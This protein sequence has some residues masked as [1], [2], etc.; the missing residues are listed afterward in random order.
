LGEDN[1]YRLEGRG[2]VAVIAPWTFPLAIICGMA[3]GALAAGNCAILKPAAQSPIIA[4]KLAEA[5]HDAGVPGAVLQYLPGPGSVVGQALVEHRDVDNIAFTGSREVGLSIVRAAAQVSKGQR[6]VKR[7]IAEM[8][9]KN[10]IIIDDD[11]DLDQAVAGAVISAFGYAGQKC[12]ACSRLIIAGSA[13]DEALARLGPAVESLIV[14]PAHD[15]ATFVPPVIS[16]QA[17]DKINGYI[18]TGGA[19]AKVLASGRTPAGPGYYVAP[20]VFCDVDETSPL[21]QDEIFGP[22]LSVFQA[23]S[24]EDALRIAMNSAFALT[25]GVYSRNPRH[26]EDARRAFRVGNLYINRKITGAIVGRQPFGGLAMSGIG[27]KAGGPD[28]LLQFME[29]RVISENT[30]RRGF[31]P[32]GHPFHTAS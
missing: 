26:I 30:M 6:N 29:P 14:G 7:V 13:Y 20:T 19:T 18:E 2:V 11:A 15:P 5:L 12:S 24:F 27:D 1:E 8:G 23:T 17:R 4:F 16:A 32:E 28:Y 3:S 31:A 9:G 22:V 21:A 25:G 10:A